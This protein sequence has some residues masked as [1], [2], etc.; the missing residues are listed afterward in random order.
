[1]GPSVA[2]APNKYPSDS[3]Q[4]GALSPLEPT[5]GRRSWANHRWHQERVNV[6]PNAMYEYV[7]V[8]RCFRRY[9]LPGHAPEKPPL[10]PGDRVVTLGS[11]FAGELRRALETARFAAGS[12]WIPSGL[13][14][15]FAIRD[16][17]SWCVVGDTTETGWRY[18]RSDDGRI[19]EW[20]PAEER[21]AYARHLGSAGCFVFTF[22]LAEVWKD[23]E[24][25]KTFWR[26]VPEAIFDAKRHVFELST[27]AENAANI[28]AIIDLVRTVNQQA[29]IVLTLSPVPL[30]ATFRDISCV[31]AD[32]VSK[33]VLRVALDEVMRGKLPAVYY[34]PSF[35][36]VRS[37]GAVLPWS[38]YGD[39]DARHANR[40]LVQ[41]I[42]DAFVD[43]FYGAEAARVFHDRLAQAG[44]RV[45]Q[46]RRFRTAIS[47]FSRFRAY[48]IAKL[49][50]E[51][52]KHGLMRNGKSAAGSA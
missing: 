34:W 2:G 36:L 4:L 7:N 48:A 6:L 52:A 25:G 8:R 23:A 9:V 5:S 26:G 31:T 15:T 10:T 33:A 39:P 14:N 12:F 24:T 3:G 50:I 35:E 45:R 47:E 22:G 20:T 41:S 19:H 42:L 46:P 43:A 51:L 17:L 29:P 18:E 21:A 13:N 27:V 30:Q 38:A 32:C 40:F 11:C 1:M 37:I 16:F 28:R 49:R 44:Q